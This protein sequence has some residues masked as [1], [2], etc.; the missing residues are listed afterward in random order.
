[1]AVGQ[2][3]IY[4]PETFG[5]ERYEHIWEQSPF[6]V[7][8]QVVTQSDGLGAQYSLTGL[9]SLAGTPIAFIYDRNTLGRFS[10][11]QGTM[12]EAGMELVSIEIDPDPRQSKATIRVGSEQASIGYDPAA[13]LQ[14]ASAEVPG[15]APNVNPALANP[16]GIIQR[17]TTPAP[18]V[19]PPAP[20]GQTQPPGAARTIKRRTINIPTN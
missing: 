20:P 2:E 12:S 7:E 19:I 11:A 5:I 17:A 15:Q 13:L 3:E 10:V 8:T 9:A 18:N 14:T 6:I 16:P 1:M 4:S